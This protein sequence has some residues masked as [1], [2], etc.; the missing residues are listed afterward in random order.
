M[1][2]LSYS[3]TR[4]S[5]SQ[6]DLDAA[7]AHADRTRHVVRVHGTLTP[8]KDPTTV[9]GSRSAASALKTAREGAILRAARDRKLL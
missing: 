6:G 2:T 9:D 4:C 5:W 7:Q 3:C 8:R 1:I